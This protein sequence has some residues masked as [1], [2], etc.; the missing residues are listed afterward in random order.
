[1]H[2]GRARGPNGQ[3]GGSAAQKWQCAGCGWGETI[4][5]ST[6]CG[7]IPA[8]EHTRQ[9]LSA[10]GQISISEGCGLGGQGLSW[11][12]Q[13]CACTAANASGFTT[14]PVIFL[15]AI[16]RRYPIFGRLLLHKG[17]SCQNQQK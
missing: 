2:A 11:N 5:K 10:R 13:R 14:A 9:H 6:C 15:V 8:S 7:T 4:K 1:M 12:R 17:A 3:G 16:G